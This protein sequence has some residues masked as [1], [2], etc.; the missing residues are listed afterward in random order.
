MFR[1]EADVVG[2][3]PGYANKILTVDHISSIFITYS[4]PKFPGPA[5]NS[6]KSR[7]AASIALVLYNTEGPWYNSARIELGT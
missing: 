1:I 7:Q 3:V 2:L 5:L 4:V 6:A